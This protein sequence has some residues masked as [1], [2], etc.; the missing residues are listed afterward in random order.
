VDRADLVRHREVTNRHYGWVPR[1][2]LTHAHGTF[3]VGGELRLHDGHHVGSVVSGSGLPPGTEPGLGYYDFHPRTLAAGLFGREEWDVTDALRVTADLAWRHQEYA[4]RGDRFDGVAFD[5]HYDFALPRLALAWTASPALSAFASLAYASREPALGDLYKGESVGNSALIRNG[6]PLVRPEH[7]TDAELGGTWRSERASATLNLFRMNFTDELVSAGQFD[8]DLNEPITG[9]AARSIHQGAELSATLALPAGE[10]RIEL[11]GNATLSDNHFVRYTEH[12][13]PAASDEID[14]DGKALGF[15]PAAMA[16]A[17]G[18]VL[19]RG[20]T[21]GASAA[22]ADRIYVDNS[23]TKAFSIP[24]RTVI[25]ALVGVRR[26]VGQQRVEA[27]LRVLN[28]F[29]REYATGGWVDYDPTT[30]GNWTPWLTPAA[31]RNWI[32]SVRVEW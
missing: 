32:A 22:Y 6:R 25:D 10:A 5:Q 16:N 20:L 28:V 7:V 31:T 23:E 13:G 12:W 24:P 29:D 27:S 17:G 4:M 2:R 18:R 30:P 8:T 11:D 3:T 14:Y 19:W 9:N 26:A 1:A 15:F 21:L